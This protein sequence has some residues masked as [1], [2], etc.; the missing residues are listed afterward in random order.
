LLSRFFCK[1]SIFADPSATPLVQSY[2]TGFIDS[3]LGEL[4]VT[5]KLP[6]SEIVLDFGGIRDEGLEV[7]DSLAGRV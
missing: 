4:Q 2:I 3:F 6:F 1:G 5:Y 7:H